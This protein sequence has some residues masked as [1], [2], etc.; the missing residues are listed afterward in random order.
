MFNVFDVEL[1]KIEGK[2]FQFIPLRTD[3]VS[4]YI[5]IG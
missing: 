1:E 5:P 3:I 4:K 2:M